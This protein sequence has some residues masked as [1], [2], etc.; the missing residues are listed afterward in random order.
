[1]RNGTKS[2]ESERKS[3][4]KKRKKQEKGQKTRMKH[5]RI[6]ITTNRRDIKRKPECQEN[7]LAVPVSTLPLTGQGKGPRGS[8]K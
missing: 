8:N 7:M 6:C 5:D 1:M 4:S 3:E 2:K